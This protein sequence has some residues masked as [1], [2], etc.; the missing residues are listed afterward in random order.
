MKL[1]LELLN[2][3]ECVYVHN[4]LVFLANTY[5]EEHSD[6]KAWFEEHPD[7]VDQY[8]EVNEIWR[9][10]ETIMAIKKRLEELE[11]QTKPK[12]EEK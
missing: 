10:V 3:Q 2:E 9:R 7:R 8:D 4:S 5:I 6:L 12:R 1:S 11:L